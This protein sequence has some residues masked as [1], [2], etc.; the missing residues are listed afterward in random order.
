[1]KIKNGKLVE[2]NYF[3]IRNI[4]KNAIEYWMRQGY[5]HLPEMLK[6][7]IDKAIEDEKRRQVVFGGAKNENKR[8]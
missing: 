8:Q 6:K 7:D 3:N 4:I 5:P 2:A 1:M